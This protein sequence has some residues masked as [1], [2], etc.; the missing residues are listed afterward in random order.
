MLVKVILT[1]EVEDLGKAGELVNVKAGYARNYLIPLKFAVLAT[2]PNL[3]W[4]KEH[5]AQ[6]EQEAATKRQKSEEQKDLV[7]SLGELYLKAYT[8]PT[9]QLFGRI[10][11]QVVVEEINTLLEGKLTLNRKQITIK[12]H[13]HGIHE[14]GTY[15]ILIN[16]GAGIKGQ[17]ALIVSEH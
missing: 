10:T 3:I 4:L 12:N 1:E 7:E 8:S 16:Y 15:E 13:Q 11:N 2:L 17:I 6:L 5:K 14:L 9:G